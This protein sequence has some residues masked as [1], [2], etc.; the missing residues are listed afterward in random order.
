MHIAEIDRYCDLYEQRLRGGERLT[1]DEF[2]RIEG[3]PRD[4]GLAAELKR[5]EREFLS[6]DGA[7]LTQPA[8]R[9]KLPAISIGPYKVLQQIGEGGMGV[10]YMAEQTAPVNRRVALKI[11]KPGMDSRQVIARFEA[12]RQAL[13]LMEH[14]HIARVLDAGTTDEGR[15][16]FVMELVKGIPITRYCDELRLTPKERLELFV[17]VCQA[18]QHAHQKGIIHRDIKPSNILVAMY[19]DRP[20]PKIIDFGLAKAIGPRLTDQTLFTQYGQIVGTIDYMSPE[21]AS[22]NQLDVDTRTDVYSLGVLL[23]E[24]LT[25]ETPFDRKRLREAALDEVLRIIR[26]E[27]P[28]RPSTRLSSHASLPTIAANRRIEPKKLSVLVRGELDWIVM[29]ALEKDRSRRYETANSL[30]ADVQRYLKDEPV[31][32]CPP[33][34]SYRLRKLAR[35]HKGAVVASLAVA[36]ALVLGLIGTSWQAIRATAARDRARTSESLA[37]ANLQRANIE[38]TRANRNEQKAQLAAQQAREEAENARESFE[39]LLTTFRA[40]D[41]LGIEGA[42]RRDDDRGRELSAGEILSRAVKQSRDDYEGKPLLLAKLLDTVGNVYRSWGDYAAAKPLLDEALQ[43][44]RLAHAPELDLAESLHSVGRCYH[45]LGHY[46]KAREC[47]EQSLE[48]RR[49]RLGPDDPEIATTRF[50]LAWLL[51]ETKDPEAESQLKEVIASGL[52]HGDRSR[53]VAL[54]RLALGALM[55]TQRRYLEAL[56]TINQA[57]TELPP[58]DELLED[59]GD[60]LLAYALR[61]SNPAAPDA[62]ADEFGAIVKKHLGARHPYYAL[63]L[64]QSSLQLGYASKDEEAGKRLEECL[65]IV[66]ET[67]GFGHPMAILPL[68]RQADNLARDGE[69]ANGEKLFEELREKRKELFGETHPLV[70]EALF[71]S[72]YYTAGHGGAERLSE[73]ERLLADANTILADPSNRDSTYPHRMYFFRDSQ[74]QEW[75]NIAFTALSPDGRL[76]FAGGGDAL[77][78]LHLTD[79]G[80][81]IQT[82]GPHTGGVSCA[83]FS[84]DGKQVLIAEQDGTCRL[85]PVDASNSTT[86]LEEPLR[87]ETLP[88]AESV[89]NL[90]FSSDGDRALACT[91][92]GAVLVWE[93][94][95]GRKIRTFQGTQGAC[96]ATF[97][98]DGQQV[99]S[100]HSDGELRLWGPS[101]ENPGRRFKKHRRP[102]AGCFIRPDG[103]TGF[104]YDRDGALWAWNI[105]TGEEIASQGRT[106]DIAESQDS[107]TASSDGQRLVTLNSRYRTVDVWDTTTGQR[108]SRRHIELFRRPGGIPRG[109]SASPNG[110]FAACGMDH[111]IVYVF[112]FP[113]N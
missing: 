28:L 104:A 59:L 84:P 36:S 111:G 57:I 52:S 65:D 27:E 8:P 29:K 51:V 101:S 18:V 49:R 6:P 92:T 96:V 11:I 4:D 10:V 44:R 35:R 90:A 66:H 68:Q 21:Q 76:F 94:K 5:L 82:L 22:F 13:S 86:P 99:L 23:Y 112:Q 60:G 91:A 62:R 113:G 31:S 34:A 67:V 14:P 105:E 58:E 26:Q 32:A 73:A 89:F 17:P 100:G 30:A 97:A 110:L 109:L 42:F 1:A 53:E 98:P 33:S 71:R 85:W 50:N 63:M 87:L 93:T 81:C 103:N 61:F 107:I 46:D 56:T 38:A 19:D 3:L 24:L 9:D 74:K 2:L 20:V 88:T 75:I 41:A 106:I 64:Y 45:D 69:F 79:T 15:P 25:G 72:A 83:V 80:E 39:F 95:S 12:E 37:E 102:V 77:S 43:L 40:Q 70:A 54:A 7:T 78:R 55:N 48:I 16:Y 108:I 47:Y